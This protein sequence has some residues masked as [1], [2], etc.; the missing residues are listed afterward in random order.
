MPFI[1][2]NLLFA[3]LPDIYIAAPAPLT[4]QMLVRLP[5]QAWPPGCPLPT[6]A[7]QL[8][9][10][11]FVRLLFST[12]RQL[13]EREAWCFH[14]PIP[15]H[16]T[17]AQIDA[18]IA[19]APPKP[20][21][22]LAGD[23]AYFQWTYADGASSFNLSTFLF[24]VAADGKVQLTDVTRE[25]F[26]PWFLDQLRERFDP[27]DQLELLSHVFGGV[28][29]KASCPRQFRIAV[30]VDGLLTHI[31]TVA[32]DISKLANAGLYKVRPLIWLD[33]P[34][35]SIKN[36]HTG[37]WPVAA[38]PTW[39]SPVNAIH[40]KHSATEKRRLADGSWPRGLPPVRERP[41]G[42][43]D[44][45]PAVDFN[46]LVGPM[47]P[48]PG[49]PPVD[50]PFELTP[51]GSPCDGCHAGVIHHNAHGRHSW[52]GALF[53]LQC[54]GD[55]T[56]LRFEPLKWHKELK[57]TPRTVM[58]A[59]APLRYLAQESGEY[60][61]AITTDWRVWFWQFGLNPWELWTAFFFAVVRIGECYAFCLVAELVAN[62]GRSHVSN[63]ASAVGSR[64][65]EPIRL[66]ADA[67]ESSLSAYD[68]PR[69]QRLVEQ[70]RAQF[71]ALQARLFWCG[72]YTDDGLSLV[73]GAMRAA[74]IARDIQEQNDQCGIWMAALEKC[75]VGTFADHIGGRFI[76]NAN[77]STLTPDKRS[78]TLHGCHAMARAELSPTDFESEHGLL[79]HVADL[80]AIE[81]SL[82]NGLGRMLAFARQQYMPKV[83][84]TSD[85]LARVLEFEQLVARRPYAFI[86]AA[87]ATVVLQP[88]HSPSPPSVL[89]SS[90]SCTGMFDSVTGILDPLGAPDPAIFVHAGSLAV[91]IRLVGAW[92][93]LHITVT[94][95]LG[96]ALG[97]LALAPSFPCSPLLVQTDASAALAF[98]RGRS[99]SECLQRIY[100]RWRAEPDVSSFL[101]R[102]S[103]QHAAGRSNVV[104]DAGSRGYWDV[105]DA[106]AA[107]CGVRLTLLEP[108]PAAISFLADALLIALDYARA[109]PP[110]LSAADV[111]DLRF[112]DAGTLADVIARAAYHRVNASSSPAGFA[113]A[114]PPRLSSVAA[115]ASGLPRPLPM[116]PT[117][118][119]VRLAFDSTLGYP[120]EG[121]PSRPSPPRRQRTRNPRAHASPQP[122]DSSW[123][124]DRQ[125]SP[126]P[127][128]RPS[129]A[130][131]QPLTQC[132]SLAF[133][134]PGLAHSPS[135]ASSVE[136]PR[137]RS[138]SRRQASPVPPPFRAA[139]LASRPATAG[140][141]RALATRQI[142]DDIATDS[143]RF[144][145]CPSDPARARAIVNRIRDT[146]ASARA[147]E[148]RRGDDWGYRWYLNG[149]D[150]LGCDPIRPT[151]VLHAR[152]E[153]MLGGHVV[154]NAAAKM[155]PRDRSRKAADP[156]SAWSAY[157]KARGVLH[158]LGCLLPPLDEV[159]DVLRGLL[160]DFVRNYGDDV[161]VTQKKQPFSR[162]HELALE[163]SL[164]ERTA[165][166]LRER[167]HLILWIILCFLRNIGARG[168]E[169][170]KGD[171]FFTR[172][173]VAPI[174]GG[175][176]VAPTLENFAR[177]SRIRVMPTGSKCDFTN[178]HWG[179][180]PMFFDVAPGEHLNLGHALI[181]LEREFPCPP[182]LRATFPIL[183]DPTK[184]VHGAPPP[185]P[186][187]WLDARHSKLLVDVLGPDVA[188]QR[189][190]H[191]WRVTLGC[192]LRAARDANHPDGRSLEIVKAFGRW[193][194]DAAVAGYARLSA[195]AY[196]SHVRASLAADAAAV[197]AP[198]V[199]AVMRSVDPVDM[200]ENV[201]LAIHGAPQRN[202]LHTPASAATAPP[203]A[204]PDAAA[205]ARMRQ[206]LTPRSSAASGAVAP[207]ARPHRRRRR[208]ATLAGS[209]PSTPEAPP[210]LNAS[211][212][213][214]T[215]ANAHGRLVIVSSTLWPDHPCDENGGRG[216][217]AMLRRVSRGVATL[218]FTA[219][220]DAQG[221]RD[222]WTYH[223]KLDAIETL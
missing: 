197:P 44:G 96:S 84:L 125:P 171:L 69:L 9:R 139:P 150:D 168:S 114:I 25:A 30:N 52:W 156:S 68:P 118:P 83:V 124:H 166:D 72:C 183:F 2:S 189:T 1:P 198:S 22:L 173:N 11:W 146:Q 122:V 12:V 141:A 45:P 220:R 66:A 186:K 5:P 74:L 79:W 144:A 169:L 213:A 217:T 101:H 100:T 219:L 80:L 191:S 223:L 172:S 145:L 27:G 142:A 75:P 222:D 92:R 61:Y 138:P 89:I 140:A 73:L 143:S 137:S 180:H 174:V 105:L 93:L 91:R 31:R 185:V 175:S 15:P 120:G 202:S 209:P 7:T 47:R 18:W 151:D 116:L 108:P 103:A 203:S 16:A 24:D 56:F 17:A 60:L 42:P 207:S 190:V 115:H 214:L 221:R 157:K 154:M 170:C 131:P 26:T 87:V 153:A 104:D 152:R 8:I 86:T 82:L 188:A 165:D 97:A 212:V 19:S 147:A 167:L 196:A 113:T 81:R 148:T 85:G 46:S 176:V 39:T 33:G 106:Y 177:A 200:I 4:S 6:H 41:H 63:V 206:R 37:A 117:D 119:D 94:E 107:A 155:R 149:C 162:A 78:R 133:A 216:W 53:C 184:P 121:P 50:T 123:S 127:P 40:K 58:Q 160:R 178:K 129:P 208:S 23:G 95:T 205:V 181:T 32:D 90:D 51:F 158:D 43:P 76:I 14:H 164:R 204:G 134:V 109:P 112:A 187:S 88:L 135:I 218:R 98:L 38:S 132:R 193:R 62:M 77:L 99:Q 20:P 28:Q 35:S 211:R 199:E 49:T 215:S 54:W 64:L 130:S 126:T 57:H 65:Y 111:R 55:G 201:H 102:A 179:A 36:G 110:A 48:P 67:R 3:L 71:G 161:L 159:R 13:G 194:S 29:S 70:R 21:A 136:P 210:T 195:D 192:S 182:H 128:P 163:R 34:L 10:P 59:A